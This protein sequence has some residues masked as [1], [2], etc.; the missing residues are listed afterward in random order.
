MN[1]QNRRFLFPLL[2]FPLAA[3]SMYGY[4]GSYTRLMADDFCSVS[5]AEKFGLLRSIWYWRLNWSGRYSAFVVDWLLTKFFGAYSLYLV[6]PILLA[7]WLILIVAAIYILLRSEDKK[8]SNLR[9]S[10][11]LASIFLF[12]VLTLS[13]DIPQSFYWWNGMRSYTLPLIVIT[14]YVIL[15]QLWAS[16][17]DTKSKLIFSGVASFFLLFASAGLSETFAVLQF[18]FLIFLIGQKY[19]ASSATKLDAKIVL[20][21]AGLIGT[22]FSLIVI[23]SA[24]GNAIRRLQLPPA[25]NLINLTIIS[26]HGYIKFISDIFSSPEKTLSVF[27]LILTGIWMG[28]QY[29]DRLTIESWRV[30]AYSIGGIL[31]SFIC[32]PPSVFGYSEFPPPRTLIIPVYILVACILYSC[33]LVGSQYLGKDSMP[34]LGRQILATMAILL[35]GFSA[36][37]QTQ[38]LYRERAIYVAYAENWDKVDAQILGAKANG[39]SSV[40]VSTTENWAKLNTLNDNSKFWVN[41]CYSQYYGIPVFGSDSQSP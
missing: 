1:K 30:S 16:Q 12:V 32:F 13:P 36:I 11:S 15:F 41:V 20:L 23:V 24:P 22:I 29:K 40:T 2:I 37:A 28:G 17:L 6:P 27:G 39:E 9:I 4:L 26:V 35:I 33:F 3:L 25:P 38:S 5:Y 14:L 34:A 31:L 19:L 10:A 21:L 18:F 8:N 7:T